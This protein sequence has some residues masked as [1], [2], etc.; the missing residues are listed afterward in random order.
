MSELEKL[1]KYIKEKKLKARLYFEGIKYIIILNNQT[2]VEEKTTGMHIKW[3]QAFGNKSLNDVLKY[4]TL[5][6][7]IITG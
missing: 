2:L 5:S 7:I 3:F 4:F 1:R 6:K